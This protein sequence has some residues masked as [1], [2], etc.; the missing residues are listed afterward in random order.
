M[1]EKFWTMK[2]ISGM[3]IELTIVHGNRNRKKKRK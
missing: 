2:E 3:F 1:N